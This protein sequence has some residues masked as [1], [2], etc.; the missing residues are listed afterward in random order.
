MTYAQLMI[1]QI[2][3]LPA[4]PIALSR[5]SQI[6]A[7]PDSGISDVVEI[8]RYEPGLTAGILKLANSAYFGAVS[9]VGSIHQAVTRLGMQQVFRLVVISTMHSTMNRPLSGYDLPPGELWR[10][11][12]AAAL[13]TKCLSEEIG[14]AH[15]ETAFTAAL[16][17][18][19]GKMIIGNHL[20]TDFLAI[21]AIATGRQ[22]SFEEAEREVI[23]ADHAQIGA[24]LLETWGIPQ[25][26]VTSVRWHHEPDALG[27]ASPMVDL[28]H[29]ADAMCLSMGIGPGRDGLYY[30]PSEAARAR[31][32]I[33]KRTMESVISRTLGA[34]SEFADLFSLPKEDV[35]HVV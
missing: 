28:V 2:E 4:V 13:A 20:K 16:L 21:E 26:I 29:V 11:S 5:L 3:T 15:A 35:H 33:S 34:L 23:G 9:S 6:L 30:R 22:I 25:E 10:H 32:S 8:V 27:S 24:A 1:K 12:V 18:D 7:D 17:H 19:I 31:C 14:I